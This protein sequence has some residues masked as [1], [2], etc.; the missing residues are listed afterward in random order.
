MTSAFPEEQTIKTFF[1][2]KI[3]RLTL[4]SVQYP[5]DYITSIWSCEYQHHLKKKK[6]HVSPRIEFRILLQKALWRKELNE[7][8]S[9]GNVASKIYRFKS[10]Q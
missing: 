4:N 9:V 2:D 6:Y 3:S 8:F 5:V 1:S 10:V 7:G